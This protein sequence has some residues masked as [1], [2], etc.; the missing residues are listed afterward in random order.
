MSQSSKVDAPQTV[1]IDGV[2]YHKEG[3]QLHPCKIGYEYSP[4]DVE[5][6]CELCEPP[7]FPTEEA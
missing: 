7:Q 6:T 3:E 1:V 2:K 4:G 5:H